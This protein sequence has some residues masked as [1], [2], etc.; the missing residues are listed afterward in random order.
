[1]NCDADEKID[2]AD[3]EQTL[4]PSIP[5]VSKAFDTVNHGKL[6]EYISQSTVKYGKLVTF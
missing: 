3:T 1:M 6:L 5:S 2:A 4:Y